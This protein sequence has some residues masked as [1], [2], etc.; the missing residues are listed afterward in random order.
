MVYSVGFDKINTLVKRNLLDDFI[1]SNNTEGLERS[2]L[3]Y[4]TP[5]KRNKRQGEAGFRLGFIYG[6]IINND[7]DGNNWWKKNPT[8]QLEAPMSLKGGRRKTRKR[9]KRKGGRRKT[10]KNKR[11]TRRKSKKRRRRT[12]RRKRR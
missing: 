7:S 2:Y 4:K 12:R 8:G 11:K 1:I 5:L 10:R 3:N 6:K 9:R